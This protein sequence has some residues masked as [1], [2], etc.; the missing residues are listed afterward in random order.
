[1]S[2]IQLALLLLQLANKLADWGRERGQLKAG[3]D[4]AIGRAS[5]ELLKATTWGKAIAEKI[6]VLD[7]AG[8]DDLTDGLG[9]DD[10]P[11]PK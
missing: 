6:D 3:E 5:L 2:Y 7:K 9:R 10:P 4:A 8:L 11:K 1:M